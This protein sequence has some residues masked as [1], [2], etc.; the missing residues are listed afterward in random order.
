MLFRSNADVVRI[1]SIHKSKGL[2]FPVTFV[3]GLSKRFNMQDASQS[4]ILDMDLG[5][6]ADY[7]DPERRIRNRTLRR[8]VLSG[9]LREDSL[10]EEMRL[11]YVA[12]T[13]AREKLILTGVLENAA[14]KWEKC[15]ELGGGMLT[16]LDFM[17]AGSFLDFLLPVLPGTCIRVSVMGELEE[18]IGR[19]HV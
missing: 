10:S 16:S 2:E 14:E 18:E 5:L 11:L 6:A 13:R 3:A 4:L 8:M 9:K 12:M 19:A 1:M 7:V 15:R 17:E